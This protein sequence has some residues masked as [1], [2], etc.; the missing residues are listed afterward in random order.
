[1]RK[2]L[3]GVFLS[4]FIAIYP[5]GDVKDR[6]NET[7]AITSFYVYPVALNKTGGE[8]SSA[9]IIREEE[10]RTTGNA[11][12]GGVV[13]GAMAGG[14]V[15]GL[16]GAVVGGVAGGAMGTLYQEAY[17]D[18]D[19]IESSG[20][21]LV[22]HT[23]RGDTVVYDLMI[24]L[25]P[26][27][28]GW[29]KSARDEK[30]AFKS[31]VQVFWITN[32]DAYEALF[33]KDRLQDIKNS[34]SQTQS[35]GCCCSSSVDDGFMEFSSTKH[36]SENERELEQDSAFE[37]ELD[38]SKSIG[39]ILRTVDQLKVNGKI[40][41]CSWSGKAKNCCRKEKDVLNPVIFT[42]KLL[43]KLK[44]FG[45]IQDDRFYTKFLGAA[46]VTRVQA[47]QNIEAI[48][49]SRIKVN[50]AKVAELVENSG[51]DVFNGLHILKGEKRKQNKS[52]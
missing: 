41:S 15:G 10:R 25:R 33:P 9:T 23:K 14:A 22:F 16:P 8:D 17:N 26:V 7:R 28:P 3:L 1:M 5:S 24:R 36:R 48:A 51:R 43:H 6:R 12:A 2:I 46:P 11:A 50:S 45:D 34:L 39:R 35:S 31:K 4:S 19:W 49:P 44:V 47:V 38:V 37:G 52:S 40:P 29:R 27:P 20:L 18:I 42:F 30:K 13:I 32:D 21:D